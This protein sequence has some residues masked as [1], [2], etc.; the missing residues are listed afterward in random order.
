MSRKIF[1]LILAVIM[2]AGLGLVL[3]PAQANAGFGDVNGDGAINSTDV[4]MLRRR[5]AQG[6]ANNLGTFIESNADVNGDGSVNAADV[7][8]LRRHVAATDPSTVPLGPAVTLPTGRFLALTTDDGPAGNTTGGGNNA[9]ASILNNLQ[10]LNTRSTVV[11]GRNGPMPCVAGRVGRYGNC[12]RSGG[13][14]CGTVSRAHISFY[15]TGNAIGNPTPRAD[16]RTL[17][18]RM[19]AEGH[20]V[21]NHTV[22]HA[23]NAANVRNEINNNNNLIRNALHGASALTDFYGTTWNSSNPYQVFSFRPNNF[24]MNNDFRGVD[25][26]TGMPWIFAG[27]DV[28]DWRGHTANMMRDWIMDGSRPLNQRPCACTDPCNFSSTWNSYQ[29]V[30]R[31]VNAADGGIVL[32]HDTL[33]TTGANA[34]AFMNQI[35]PLLQPHGYHFVTI[36]K[37]FEYMDAEWAWTTNATTILTGDGSGTRFNDWVVRGASRTGTGV[38]PSIVRGGN[39]VT[40]N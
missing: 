26:E 13:A 39:F 32:N 9:T 6:N 22:G 24:R 21:E 36:P 40:G 34:A 19:L 11:C 1:P 37:M 8:L 5:V 4:T 27:L 28:D 16:A 18:R 14:S 20:S 23:I 2:L 29:G 25:R 30:N 3:I 17:M 10:T 35:V 38:R 15:V 7:T 12:V 31:N 33:S